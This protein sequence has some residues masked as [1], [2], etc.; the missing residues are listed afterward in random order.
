METTFPASVSVADLL[1]AGKLVK[2]SDKKKVTL[3]FEKFNV[4]LQKSIPG[5][6]KEVF[7]EFKK[8]GSGGFR[9]AFKATG[10]DC[11]SEW[12]VKIYNDKAR[13]CSHAKFNN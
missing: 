7:I 5:S 8:F 13:D 9:D 2:P 6:G 4:E 12:V 1:K 10:K 3:T 11:S